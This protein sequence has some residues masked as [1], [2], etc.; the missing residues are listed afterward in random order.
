MRFLHRVRLLVSVFLFL[1]FRATRCYYTFAP[2][3]HP[4]LSLAFVASHFPYFL[5]L[6]YSIAFVYLHSIVSYERYIII[7]ALAPPRLLSHLFLAALRIVYRTPH[8]HACCYISLERLVYHRNILCVHVSA[9]CH[10]SRRHG[11]CSAI[12]RD[13][14][15][16]GIGAVP[17]Y[18]RLSL[19]LS[20]VFR[21]TVPHAL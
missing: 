14:Y 10:F 1:T 9:F 11:P 3:H 15:V 13:S 5:C 17:C 18:I 6:S 20:P 16:G 4:A 2:H 21:R 7:Y 8:P 19:R 12:S